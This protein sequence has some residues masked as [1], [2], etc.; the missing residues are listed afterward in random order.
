MQ[1]INDALEAVGSDTIQHLFEFM[2]IRAELAS[3]DLERLL[4]RRSAVELGLAIFAYAEHKE[5]ICRE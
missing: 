2:E 4:T 3:N 1:G 5:R